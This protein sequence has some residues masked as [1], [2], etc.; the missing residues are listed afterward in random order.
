M[1]KPTAFLL[2]LLM[3]LTAGAQA[4]ATAEESA[5]DELSLTAEIA[6]MGRPVSDQ[7]THLT[8]GNPTRVSGSFFTDM[9]SN[10]TSD[11]DVRALLYGYNTVAW[12]S[13]LQFVADPMV[14]SSVTTRKSRG[15]AVYTV[16]LQQ[17]LVY[18]D[19]K[20]PIT[21]EDY[22]FSLLLC[23]SPEAAELG[24]ESS[25]YEKIVGYDEYHEGKTDALRGVRLMG[26]HTFS[27]TVK[28][29]HEPFFFDLASIWCI[30]YPKSELAPYCAV[31]DTK[32]GARLIATGAA[33]SDAP[34]T[35][36]LL[37]RTIFDETIGYM[38]HPKLTSGPYQLTAFDPVTGRV[39][40]T[41]NPY[42]KGNYEGVKPVIDTLTLV[43]VAS[44]EMI[45]QL[46]AGEVDLLNK[47]VDGQAVR[48]GLALRGAGFD[49]KNYARMGYGFCAFSCEKGPQQFTAVRQAIAYCVDQD[50]FVQAFLGD[51]G[52]PVYG[53][54]GLGQW[55]MLAASGSIRPENATL[56]DL[57]AWDRLTLEGLNRYD[58][59]MEKAKKLLIQDGWTLNE[60]G[61][62]F[63]EGVDDVRYKKVGKER[64]R[65]SLRFAQAENNNGATL[66]VEQLAQAL[67]QIGCELLVEVVPFAT[68]LEDYYRTDG[69]RKYDMNFM[70]TNF[71]SVF[72]P[73]YTFNAGGEIGG[74]VNTSGLD[75][76]RLMRLAWK[77]H[78]TE[79]MDLLTY[80][81]NWLAFQKRF[82]ELLPTLPLYTN[83]YFDFHTDWL[84]NYEPNTYSGWASAILYAYIADPATLPAA[85]ADEGTEISPMPE[86]ADEVVIID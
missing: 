35:V 79:P 6:L 28:A 50:A 38:S 42:F 17:D 62:K 52:L 18:C 21:A 51:T 7:P 2:A 36:D 66:I 74:A 3:L 84:Q 32:K 80:Q 11:I 9:W 10:N 48:D 71:S 29:D 49:V 40:F 53:Y 31:E 63:V 4:A 85:D 22:V 33:A 23:A 86:D 78:K 69:E 34:L 81:K 45:G 13:Q 76:D 61:G 68:L 64:M 12:T 77:M 56:N 60:Q 24:A 30:P 73:Y 15:N 46:E 5:A 59:D 65:L 1:R 82:N 54:Y 44:G 37:R 26:T 27:I 67:P 72:D 43:P 47:C 8:V 41:L 58:P 39:D 75:D 16:S 57:K 14:V 70:G 83:V 25:R 19:G 20:T 55:M